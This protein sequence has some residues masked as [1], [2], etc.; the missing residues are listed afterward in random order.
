MKALNESLDRTLKDRIM[1]AQ[2]AGS[3]DRKQ[4]RGWDW[5]SHFVDVPRTYEGKEVEET[6]SEDGLR[7]GEGNQQQGI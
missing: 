3:K 6:R 2:K 5:K 1:V 7:V 4:A